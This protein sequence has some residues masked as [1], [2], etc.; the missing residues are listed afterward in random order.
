MVHHHPCPYLQTQ[1]NRG[2]SLDHASLLQ[3]SLY[4]CV[5]NIYNSL[6]CCLDNTSFAKDTQAMLVPVKKY[7]E[8]VAFSV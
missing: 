8:E 1:G 5:R 4:F 3:F 2:T 7:S 6:D